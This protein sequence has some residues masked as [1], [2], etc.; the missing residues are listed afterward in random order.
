MRPG[1]S[2]A[3]AWRLNRRVL[4]PA[5]YFSRAGKVTKSAPKPRFWNPFRSTSGVFGKPYPKCRIVSP[6]APLPLILQNFRCML[7]TFGTMWAS[8]PTNNERTLF[9][10]RRGRCPHRP[11]ISANVPAFQ[12]V[13]GSGANA[14]TILHLR[15]FAWNFQTC[16]TRYNDIP[17]CGARLGSQETLVSCGVLWVLSFTGERKYPA[18]GTY[19]ATSVAPP[20]ILLKFFKT[21][22]QFSL[23][24]LQ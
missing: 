1:G 22:S 7:L 5:G 21:G 11:A 19:R 23:G 24:V 16:G 10:F 18:G 2:P 13:S 6:S 15:P 4:P 8:S 17:M 3:G 14:E 20:K 9:N 12:S